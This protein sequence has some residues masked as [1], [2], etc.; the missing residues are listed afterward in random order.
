[1]LS[2]A[3][4]PEQVDTNVAAEHERHVLDG[5]LRFTPEEKTFHVESGDGSAIAGMV[6]RQM[7]RP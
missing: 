4:R 6:F 5:R 1:M 7:W 3:L 2:S